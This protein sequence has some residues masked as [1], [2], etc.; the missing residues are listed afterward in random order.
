M[1][2]LVYFVTLPDGDEWRR[3]G[4]N[5]PWFIGDDLSAMNYLRK[6]GLVLACPFLRQQMRKEIER[7]ERRIKTELANR[8]VHDDDDFLRSI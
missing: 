5:A 6:N 8:S 2:L 4:D 1:T 3:V 7:F